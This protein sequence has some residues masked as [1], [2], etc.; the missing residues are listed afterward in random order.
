[1]KRVLGLLLVFLVL[2]AFRALGASCLQD[3]R[4][5]VQL[6]FETLTEGTLPLRL[7]DIRKAG[8]DAVLIA[9]VE[10]YDEGEV[11]AQKLARLSRALAF[12]REAGLPT[13][14]WTTTLGYGENAGSAARRFANGQKL[15][16]VTGRA[17][18]RC[19]TDGNVLAANCENLRDFVWAG[20]AFILLDDDFI[21]T[22]RPG[23]GCVCSE[24][25]RRLTCK[26]QRPVTT[27]EVAR[28]FSGSPNAV[29]TAY[30]DTLGETLADCARALRRAVD[31][32]NPDVGIGLCASYTHYDVEGCDLAALLRVLAGRARPPLLRVSGATYWPVVS[33]RVRGAHLGAVVEFVRWQIARWRRS[34]VRLLDENDPH[35]RAD[36]VVPA[37]LCE[38]YD[39]CMIAEGDIVRN[40]YILRDHE[41]AID[42]AYLNAHLVQAP[43]HAALADAF[44]GA[45]PCGF[46]VIC[47]EHRLREATLPNGAG[48]WAVMKQFSHPM[49]GIFATVA[50]G[51]ATHYDRTAETP[52][53]AFGSAA[54]FLTAAD[55]S[56]G[57]LLDAEGAR[58]LAARGIDV[59]SGTGDPLR[60]YAN[61]AGEKYAVI[62]Q[63][64][65]DFDFTRQDGLRVPLANAW[66]FFTDAALPVEV[67]HAP[68]VYPLAKRKPDGSLVVL[69][70]NMGRD[71]T[72]DF[73]VRMDGVGQRV[74]LPGYGFAIL[75]RGRDPSLGCFL[76]L[77]ERSLKELTLFGLKGIS[78]Y[79]HHAAMFGKE[80]EQIYVFIL[81]ALRTLG[82]RATVGELTRLVFKCGRE[83]VNAMALLDAANTSAYGNPSLAHVSPGV[84]P[85]PRFCDCIL[86]SSGS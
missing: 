32:V 39:A 57:V 76:V 28:A 61:A 46:K 24:H 11:R 72:G 4:L 40:K 85:R 12:F 42:P 30:L 22:C 20:A 50:N 47:P 45:A 51:V 49:A 43:R 21:Q 53:A 17:T 80:N 29:R 19:P 36:S 26:L 44:A 14:V 77:N 66:R 54:A 65:W 74:S 64:A 1:M 71:P 83:A 48:I 34:D 59:G 75:M 35:P 3:A 7:A 52:C 70:C 56:R 86:T 73:T 82:R 6:D 67:V 84:G 13:A 16:S 27:N 60:L 81:Q 69:L 8:A 15:L 2:S 78:A 5:V 31:E 55:R 62:S 18:A 41:G 10:F 33:P 63:S 23:L 25:L 58:L 38:L 37:A 9:L 79:C 68:N